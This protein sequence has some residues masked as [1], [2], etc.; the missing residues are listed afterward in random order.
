MAALGLLVLAACGGSP[1]AAA[2]PLSPDAA[3]A[4]AV[5]ADDALRAAAAGQPTSLEGVLGGRL[6]AAERVRLEAR[7][8]HQAWTS[9]TLLDR[10]AVHVEAGGR[11]PQVV[12]FLRTRTGAAPGVRQWSVV[13]GR[14]GPRWVVVDGHDLPPPQWWPL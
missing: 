2:P 8:Q 7:R 13:L 4:V 11:P 12:L 10:R 9:E 14:S 5:R 3:V 1:A 6:L